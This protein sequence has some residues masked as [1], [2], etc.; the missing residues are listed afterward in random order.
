MFLVPRISF[1]MCLN[2]FLP[3]LSHNFAGVIWKCLWSYKRML[4][5]LVIMYLTFSPLVSLV[6]MANE[7]RKQLVNFF[8]TASG[9]A[10]KNMVPQVM[11]YFLWTDHSGCYF[12][13]LLTI[14]HYI[15]SWG[16]CLQ[17]NLH[18]FLYILYFHCRD[19]ALQHN[20]PVLTFNTVKKNISH[21]ATPIICSI[22]DVLN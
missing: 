12:I 9:G 17:G 3:D 20:S 13:V 7:C 11:G 18:P 22:F 5:F 6:V 2:V 16:F 1:C 14:I 10:V 4:F 8:F 21:L 15:G 19:I